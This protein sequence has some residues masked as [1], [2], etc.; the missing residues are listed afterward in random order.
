MN[1]K[2]ETYIYVPVIVQDDIEVPFGD[3]L[4]FKDINMLIF[5]E[6]GAAAQECIEKIKQERKEAGEESELQFKIVKYQRV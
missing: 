4:R 1:G 5:F 6:S 3:S 2:L